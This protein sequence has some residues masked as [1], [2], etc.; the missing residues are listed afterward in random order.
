MRS[1]AL[2]FATVLTT[3]AASAAAQ[4]TKAPSPHSRQ[5][6]C[7]ISG[8]VV[9]LAGSFP[10]KSAIVI[11]KSNDDRSRNAVHAATDSDGHFQFK[12]IVAGQYRLQVTHIGYVAQDY[13]QRTINTPGAVLALSAGQE[14]K[15]LLFRLIP[16]ATISGRVQ[17]EDGDALPWAHVSALREAYN[18]GKRTLQTEES[19]PTNDRGEYR[20][21]GLRPGRYLIA[22]IYHPG[23]VPNANDIDHDALEVD[24]LTESYVRTFYPGSTDTGKAEAVSVKA[25][26]EIPSMD[27]LLRP[28]SVYRVK[29]R[30]FNT[31]AADRKKSNQ[32]MVYLTPR[33]SRVYTDSIALGPDNVVK[34]N[35]TFDLPAVPPGSYVVNAEWS[36]DG[37]RNIARQN[38]EIGDA[39]VEGL[40]LTIAKGP[41]VAG[42]VH[43][44]GSSA[45]QADD[46]MSIRAGDPE[47]E[48]STTYARV[49]SEGSFSLLEVPSG[50]L[51]V[52]LERQSPNSYIKSIEYGGVDAL[53]DGF[54]ARAGSNA[55]LEIALG[56]RGAQVKGIVRDADGLPL[57]GVWVVLV[58]EA[59]RRGR[60]DL[61]K[62]VRTDQHGQYTITGIAPGEYRLFSWDQVEDGAWQDPDFVKPY[63]KKGEN[64]TVQD[65]DAKSAA[66]TVIRTGVED[67]PKP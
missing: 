22:A 19:V 28:T 1:L 58:P 45:A 12:G 54:T 32:A 48:F 57:V 60:L 13:G 30:V 23:A 46:D 5:E 7:K 43:W 2:F 67:Q 55:T 25:G 20:L 27:F 35:G 51:R 26:E 59:T 41:T 10:L 65:G 21:F 8:T 42:H 14:M 16:S 29:G 66:L 9:A 3:V 31:L 18:D 15:D 50:P 4:S 53:E 49:E 61:Y 34:A 63:E 52:T 44:D 47:D 38:I 33:N 56:L 6:D 36:D 37:K 11:L 39:D 24:H 40:L 64:I 17:N 62:N